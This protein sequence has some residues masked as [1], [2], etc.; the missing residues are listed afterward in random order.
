M[1]EL[2]DVVT[3]LL[4]SDDRQ[5]VLDGLQMANDLLIVVTTEQ[6]NEVVEKSRL[7]SQYAYLL[8]E[9]GA[10][11][12][13]N[14]GYA[15]FYALLTWD[16]QRKAWTSN[17]D[18]L[19]RDRHL[20]T[21]LQQCSDGYLSW[22]EGLPAGTAPTHPPLD[23][24]GALLV[25]PPP[26][27]QHNKLLLLVA[28]HKN[29]A[30][31]NE[32]HPDTFRP[33][34]TTR[35]ALLLHWGVASL[36][37]ARYT[38][39]GTTV[40]HHL[41]VLDDE[42]AIRYA[43]SRG[44]DVNARDKDG[45]TPIFWAA[46]RKVRGA[47]TIQCLVELGANVHAVS[48]A[49][50]TALFSAAYGGSAAGVRALLDAG[51][52]PNVEAD[53]DGTPLEMAARC[54]NRATAMTLLQ[55]GTQPQLAALRTAKRH[56]YFEMASLLQKA[57]GI[58]PPPAES[59]LS[60]IKAIAEKIGKDAALSAMDSGDYG[61]YECEDDLDESTLAESYWQDNFRGVME[62]A[63]AALADEARANLPLEQDLFLNA[64]LRNIYLDAFAA[65]INAG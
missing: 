21:R 49:N 48:R 59:A 28:G 33:G 63:I 16:L 29:Y 52:D 14:L 31:L 60:D 10:D 23:L 62:E 8:V 24:L 7:L 1:E 12:D 65:A 30:G 42:D 56:N 40:L 41:G 4:D 32:Y 15:I 47:H 39:K 9:Q 25:D 53:E 61:Y 50:R 64:T 44:A 37:E 34:R 19:P 13:I 18:Q 55:A 58:A 57:L 5:A 2:R 54:D 20:G 38:Y 3:A 51:A 43:I 45:Q 22:L 35:L 26:A 46:D 6:E 27:N 36:M 17:L 11:D